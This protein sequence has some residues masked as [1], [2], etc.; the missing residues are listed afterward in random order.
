MS[1]LLQNPWMLTFMSSWH[2]ANVDLLPFSHPTVRAAAALVVQN[3]RL[4]ASVLW[5]PA[6]P[7][8]PVTHQSWPALQA[9]CHTCRS[10]A[11]W[12]TPTSRACSAE[13]TSETHDDLMSLFS[14]QSTE[15]RGMSEHHMLIHSTQL[16][17]PFSSY[18]DISRLYISVDGDQLL[19]RYLEG[20][21]HSNKS[22]W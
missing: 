1:M 11:S 16:F 9:W 20:V 10:T 5:A 4:G 8:A 22:K 7:S 17:P 21:H 15:S 13:V 2:A 6:V 19:V 14:H 12:S 18:C 3:M